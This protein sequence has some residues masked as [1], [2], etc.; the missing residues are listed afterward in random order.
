MCYQNH[1]YD[2]GSH[3]NEECSEYIEANE[4]LEN[5]ETAI[6]RVIQ[7]LYGNG[8]LETAM[9]D[10]AIADIC[11]AVNVQSPVGLPRVRRPGSELYDFGVQLS[12]SFT[13]TGV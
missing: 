4:K 1:D 9:L 5:V 2:T 11:D 3:H 13:H 6:R 7:I 12:R 10:D 8:E